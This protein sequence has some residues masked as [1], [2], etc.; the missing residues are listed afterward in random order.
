VSTDDWS[1]PPTVCEQDARIGLKLGD[2]IEPSPGHEVYDE[3]VRVL[4][5]D[6]GKRLKIAPLPDPY[7][8]RREDPELLEQFGS[9]PLNSWRLSHV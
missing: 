7:G 2:V 3:R 4:A 1:R 9:D 8:A 5:G 6:T